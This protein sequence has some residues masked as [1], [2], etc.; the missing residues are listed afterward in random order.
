MKK[1]VKTLVPA[2][3]LAVTGAAQSEPLTNMLH[4]L[5]VNP[6]LLALYQSEP[7]TVIT[8]FGLNEEEAKIATS[9]NIKDANSKFAAKAHSINVETH[10]EFS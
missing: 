5:S 8:H 3:L 9:N 6:D 7:E 2:A 10:F 1:T 4:E